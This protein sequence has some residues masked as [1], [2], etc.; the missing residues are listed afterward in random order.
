MLHFLGVLDGEV[1]AGDKRDIKRGEIIWA[2]LI[3]VG[4][5]MIAGTRRGVT[6][7]GH[8]AVP[9]VVLKNPH[10]REACRL[11]AR[12]SAHAIGETL[13]EKL[14]AIRLVAVERWIQ[15]KSNQTLHRKPRS[16]VAQIVQA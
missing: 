16:K 1:P 12:K 6:F 11:Y 10:R 8:R 14:G 4:L 7:H 13:I 15:V 5:G 3:H 2:D 9:L